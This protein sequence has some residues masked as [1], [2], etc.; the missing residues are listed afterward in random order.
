MNAVRLSS[1][2]SS[3]WVV[4]WGAHDWSFNLSNDDGDDVVDEDSDG[5]GLP[6]RGIVGEAMALWSIRRPEA[7]ISMAAAVFNI[8]AH[9]AEDV[10]DSDFRPADL[11]DAIMTWSSC[12]GPIVPVDLAALVFDV[13]VSEV[14]CAIDDH[15]WM[16]VERMGDTPC[17]GHEGL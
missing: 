14:L 4:R 13:S 16:F 7:S 8:P 5:S 17:I 6:G 1:A 10:F 12:V 2:T 9:L 15:Y 11:S 3:P